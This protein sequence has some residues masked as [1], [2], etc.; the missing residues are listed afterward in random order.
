MRITSS[1][2]RNLPV[3]TESGEKLGRLSGYEIDVA[4]HA[5]VAY[6]V[7]PSRLAQPIAPTSLRIAPAQVVSISSKEMVVR[8]GTVSQRDTETVVRMPKGVAPAVSA[9]VG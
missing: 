8:D 1:Q 6:V 4:T 7:R 5:I 9:R 2:L 3:K